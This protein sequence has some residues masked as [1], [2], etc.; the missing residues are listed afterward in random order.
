MPW[1]DVPA[2][3]ASLSQRSAV[4]AK[5]LQ[6]TIL[7]AC[8]TSEVIEARWE[9]FDYDARAWTIPAERMKAGEEHRVPL[10]DEMLAILEPLKAMASDYV[11]EGQRR[12]HP[13]SNMSMLMLLRRMGQ[14]SYTFH[15]FRSSFRDTS[16]FALSV[17]RAVDPKNEVEAMLAVQM[18]ATHMATMTMAWCLTSAPVGLIG[19]FA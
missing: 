7:T 3:Y 12:H 5:A 14:G 11:F 16:N 10:T 9:E 15:G 17:V 1:R 18:A 2:F 4:A 6:F 8:R 13:L 19:G